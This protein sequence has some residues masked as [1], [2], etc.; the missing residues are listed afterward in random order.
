[1]K[2]YQNGHRFRDYDRFESKLHQPY[3]Y[4]KNGIIQHIISH[5]IIESPNRVLQAMLRFVD[6]SFIHLFRYTDEL[7]YFKNYLWKNR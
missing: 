2:A 1:M 6:E 7:K 4:K 5:K 3:D